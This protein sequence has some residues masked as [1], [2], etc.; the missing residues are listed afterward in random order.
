MRIIDMVLCV[1]EGI[2]RGC[3]VRERDHK[4]K[5]K[6]KKKKNKKKKGARKVNDV[7]GA[8]SRALARVVCAASR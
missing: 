8:V 7:P 2:A 5:K 4:T 3:T 1:R 6:R